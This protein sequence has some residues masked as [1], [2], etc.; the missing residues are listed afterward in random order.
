MARQKVY[1]YLNENFISVKIDFDREKNIVYQFDV[2]GIPDLW[3]LDSTG[4]KLTRS[5]GYV[6]EDILIAMLKY[7]GEEAFRKMD[8][9]EF[10]QVREGLK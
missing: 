3:F 2:Q 5:T 8:F 4:E 9:K 7:I 6:S 10:L 1:N